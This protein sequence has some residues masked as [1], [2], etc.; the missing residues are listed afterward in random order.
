MSSPCLYQQSLVRSVQ[1]LSPSLGRAFKI[2]R[3]R[4]GSNQIVAAPHAVNV[5]RDPPSAPS[6]QRVVSRPSDGSDKRWVISA[7]GPA[8]ACGW[9]V[10]TALREV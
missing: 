2:H 9:I 7:A 1:K 4:L 10:G 5:H 6:R 8:V 3:L